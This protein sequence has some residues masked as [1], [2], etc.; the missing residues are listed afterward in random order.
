LQE[1]VKA[2]TSVRG[3]GNSHQLRR[4]AVAVDVASGDAI[5]ARCGR[6]I[7]PGEPWD[8]DHSDDRTSYLGPSHRRCNRA[9]AG[10][11]KRRLFSR[12]W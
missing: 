5:C 10:R 7:V 2:K 8:L 1:V 12:V 6:L 3:Y 11:K 9:T 4:K